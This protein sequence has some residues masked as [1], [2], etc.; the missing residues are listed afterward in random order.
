[1]RQTSGRLSV[2]LRK[3]LSHAMYLVDSVKTRRRLGVGI[4]NPAARTSGDSGGR[5]S[6][7]T[8]VCLGFGL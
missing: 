3:H 4:P 2:W 1:M 7:S 5:S 6:S 8:T